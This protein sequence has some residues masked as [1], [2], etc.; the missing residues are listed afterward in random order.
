MEKISRSFF[1]KKKKNGN[2]AY[3]YYFNTDF[4]KRELFVGK[5]LHHWWRH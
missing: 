4:L 3:E 1:K 2:R 5:S